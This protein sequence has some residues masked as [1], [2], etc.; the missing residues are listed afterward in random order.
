MGPVTIHVIDDDEAMRQ[1]LAFLLESAGFSVST[2]ESAVAF[3]SLA[4]VAETAVV[5]TDVRMPDVSGL[6]LVQRMRARGMAHPVIMVTG[7]GDGALGAEAV[8]SGASE[9]L[10]KPFGDEA[11]LSAI[12]A[13][14][15]GG[16]PA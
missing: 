5:V 10:E 6:E 16:P 3:L 14:M 13:A 7:H 8:Q 1:S 15:R 2:H 4:D 11:L 12:N 9:V